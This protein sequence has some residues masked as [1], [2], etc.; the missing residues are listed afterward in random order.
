MREAVGFFIF[1]ATSF[2][3]PILLGFVFGVGSAVGWPGG[4]HA[5]GV[6]QAVEICLEIFYASLC[7]CFAFMGSEFDLN[8]ALC[9]FA[10]VFASAVWWKP[11]L[12][13]WRPRRRTFVQFR[14]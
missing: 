10:A 7:A 9:L 1:S 5:A 4:C 6:G 13:G 14:I 11:S 2:L 3:A 12:R 8:L